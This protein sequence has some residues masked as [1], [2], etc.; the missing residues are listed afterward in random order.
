M[1]NFKPQ[2]GDYFEVSKLTQ[3][4]YEK[5]CEL[6]RPHCDSVDYQRL[7]DLPFSYVGWD[8]DGYFDIWTAVKYFGPNARLLTYEDVFP[9]AVVETLTTIRHTDLISATIKDGDMIIDDHAGCFTKQEL[10]AVIETLQ[11]AEMMM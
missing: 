2:Q 3:E 4:Q 8:D 9:G 1:T 5:L 7:P 11:Q 6:Y 10:Q